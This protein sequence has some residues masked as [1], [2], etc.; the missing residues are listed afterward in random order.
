MEFG[1]WGFYQEHAL[2]LS[3]TEID[4]YYLPVTP[5]NSPQSFCQPSGQR[6]EP[7]NRVGGRERNTTH[8]AVGEVL[9]RSS[10]CQWTGAEPAC[11][12]RRRGVIVPP[13]QHGRI[14]M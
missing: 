1:F 6:V 8:C 9:R 10:S 14:G 2:S 13:G 7:R 11:P 4:Y 5:Q 12:R 3:T